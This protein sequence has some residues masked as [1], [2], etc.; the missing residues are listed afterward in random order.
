MRSQALSPPA[1]MPLPKYE[2]TGLGELNQTFDDLLKQVGFKR[3]A[4][5]TEIPLTLLCSCQ[6]TNV[7]TW[8]ACD[9]QQ[10][11]EGSA[12]SHA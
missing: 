3:W 11:T 8:P 12:A 5:P 10:H 4:T 7:R 1:G 9:L 6:V 2:D